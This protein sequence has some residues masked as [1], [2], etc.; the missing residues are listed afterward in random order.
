MDVWIDVCIKIG[1][2]EYI[3]ADA[4][5]R[6]FVSDERPMETRIGRGGFNRLFVGLCRLWVRLARRGKMVWGNKG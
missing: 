1:W 3:Y 4:A 6:R 2:R 5:G